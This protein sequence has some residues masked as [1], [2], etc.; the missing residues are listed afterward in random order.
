MTNKNSISRKLHK[1]CDKSLL[2][3]TQS[4][5]DLFQEVKGAYFSYLTLSKNGI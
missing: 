4:A 5:L 3:Q 1:R 2:P